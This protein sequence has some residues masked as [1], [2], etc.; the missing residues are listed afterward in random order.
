MSAPRIA[1]LEELPNGTRFRLPMSKSVEGEL[2]SKSTGCATVKI[3][4]EQTKPRLQWSL[5]TLVEV[6]P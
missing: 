2:I 5:G 3:L 6:L 4:S 1:Q